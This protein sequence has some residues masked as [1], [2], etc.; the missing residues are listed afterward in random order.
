MADVKYAAIESPSATHDALPSNGGPLA[1]EDLAF[2]ES[3]LAKRVVRKIDRRLLP[4][5]FV[6]YTFT[7]MDKT[8]LS[9]AAVLG[10]RTSTHLV[11]QQ[12]SWVSSAFYFGYLFWEYPTTL[13]IQR[14]PIGKY[15]GINTLIW[16]AVVAL[17]AA[18]TS[19]AGL[20][21]VRVLLG[22]AEATISPAFLLITSSWYTRAETP[23]RIGIWFAG[24]SLGGI[25]TS[26]L[27]YGI[28]HIES[29]PV[30]SWQ[31]LFIILGV[32]TFLCG[33][34]I[35]AFLPDSICSAKFLSDEERECARQRVA[36][37]GTGKTDRPWSSAQMREL[38]LDP[39]TYF[40]LGISLLTQIPN[41]GTQNFGNLVLTGFGFSALDSTLVILPASVLCIAAILATAWLAGR[42][43]NVSTALICAIVLCPVAGSALIYADGTSP[44]VKLFGYYLLSPGPAALPMATQL[45][46]VNFKGSTKKRRVAMAALLFM[47]Y[48][49]GNI[50]GPQFF[51]SSEAPRYPTAFRTIM[52]CYALVVVLS[53]GLRIYLT[54]VNRSR[55]AKE[56]PSSGVVEEE[57]KDG[58]ETT[59]W[60]A[61]GF[62]YRM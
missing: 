18:C 24:A 26:F 58:V 42:H 60:N 44:R 31:W 19:F 61:K 56:G 43:Q 2:L 14:L 7:F 11:G 40:F 33:P 37:A 62:R 36:L 57:S 59:D 15:V 34:F 38:F 35:L 12:Y 23:S 55:D 3:P 51:K 10:L 6:T 45:V 32:L 53:M 4:L 46:G 16:G 27:A 8:I 48:S 41:G 30:K 50:A 5:L 20:M 39:Q 13:L 25:V 9:S 52:I 21:T 28:G 47:V 17:T 49:A 1:V 29:G 54:L 22:V